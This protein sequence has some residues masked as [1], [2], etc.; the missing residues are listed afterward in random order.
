MM[1]QDIGKR[2]TTVSAA[3]HDFCT[4]T[5]FYDRWF[6]IRQA[7]SEMGGDQSMQKLLKKWGWSW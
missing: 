6:K 1:I 5:R 3:Y 4:A 2:G 7:K